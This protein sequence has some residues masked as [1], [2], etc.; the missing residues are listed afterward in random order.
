MVVAGEVCFGGGWIPLL[1]TFLTLI[2]TKDIKSI[3]NAN[4]GLSV[5]L[6]IFASIL[7]A[8]RPDV[9]AEDESF[10]GWMAT[11][12]LPIM[13]WAVIYMVQRMLFIKEG[14]TLYMERLEKTVEA[15]EASMVNG[16]ADGYFFN[17]TK[18]IG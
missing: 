16:V 1:G 8:S 4:N 17:F 2:E 10:D 18:K 9:K 3:L 5:I 14:D 15:L 6:L 7:F 13:E 11:F 12:G